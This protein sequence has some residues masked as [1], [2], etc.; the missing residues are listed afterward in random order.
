MPHSTCKNRRW[1]CSHLPCLG[2]CVVY[3]DG[4][5][6]TFDRE[7]YSFEGSCEYTLAQVCQ[8]PQMLCTSALGL[9][10]T[11]LPWTPFPHPCPGPMITPLPRTPFLHPC[12][13][14]LI[15]SLP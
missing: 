6:I 13:G 4:H 10:N 14:P 12:P 3:G 11:P 8:G 5:F 2:T 9:L 15:T 7:R 1:E